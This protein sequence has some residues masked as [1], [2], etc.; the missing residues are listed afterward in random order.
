M[1]A[2]IGSRDT[3]AGRALIYQFHD[4]PAEAQDVICNSV[5]ALRH[6]VYE[7]LEMGD[8][9][10]RETVL[11]LLEVN[12]SIDSAEALAQLLD[13]ESIRLADRAEVA[14]RRV[15]ERF[16]Q[17][18]EDADEP[19]Y[20]PDGLLV[21]DQTRQ[22]RKRERIFE[23]A[24]LLFRAL[25]VAMYS[26]GRHRREMVIEACLRTGGECRALVTEVLQLERTRRDSNGPVER[27]LTRS[28]DVRSLEYLFER[29]LD[30]RAEIRALATRCFA[31]KRG[32]DVNTNLAFLLDDR[33]D[34]EHIR[35]VLTTAHGIPWIDMMFD[36]VD[37]YAVRV[38]R[39]LS[40]EVDRS[41]LEPAERANFLAVIADCRE[42]KLSKEA[43]ARLKDM[44][45]ADS[46]KALIRLTNSKKRRPVMFALDTLIEK[47]QQLAI[48]VA[49]KLME[50]R[51][52]EI[53]TRATQ[54]ITGHAYK[55]Y[56]MNFSKMNEEQR[57][58]LGGALRNI[59]KDI[60][61][62][63]TANIRDENPEVRL[64]AVRMLQLTDNVESVE[65]HLESL[66]GDSD[67]RVRASVLGLI[68]KSKP[69]FAIRAISALLKD[70]DKRVRANAIE[71]VAEIG[72]PKLARALIPYLKDANNRIR[73]NATKAL[74]SLGI[75][76]VAE[77]MY[78]MLEDESDLMRMSAIWA[79]GETAP[80]GGE[81][82]LRDHL[83]VE[84]EEAMKARVED[85]LKKLEVAEPKE[86]DN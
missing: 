66:V 79:I 71:A 50:S 52:D 3:G 43:L 42:T 47:N 31:Q 83:D 81:N 5:Q 68:S 46:A 41:N 35:R 76:E 74:Y 2:L 22:M 48:Q 62:E 30:H 80:E 69:E 37:R 75:T 23:K 18:R 12:V 60:L 9:D 57:V 21:K 59:D 67:S 82:R 33:I 15:V 19:M 13:D 44:N 55:R 24:R 58:K 32:A 54:F 84:V 38:L 8:A 61:G 53:R 77:V 64:R 16:Q 40:H 36:H 73:G 51:W 6:V 65:T 4:L 72:E 39:R 27:Y 45:I 14:L 85:A 78:E 28:N 1:K 56:T 49:S 11:E 63:L 26:F 70:K 10:V 7:I 20:T 86:V 29:L 25:K 34:D 17:E